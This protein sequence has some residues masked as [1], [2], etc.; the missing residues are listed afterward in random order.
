MDSIKRI[1]HKLWQT[2][3]PWWLL[4]MPAG[5]LLMLAAGALAVTGFQFTM[6]A[7]STTEFCLSC[8][9]MSDN[10]EKDYKL[11]IHYHNAKGIQA[12]CADCHIPAPFI[13]KMERKLR[14]TA[15]VYYSIT[16][17]IDTPEKFAEHKWAMASKVWAEMKANDSRECR[18]CHDIE[19]MNLAAQSKQAA[20]RHDPEKMKAANMTCID[21][22]KGVAHSLPEPPMVDE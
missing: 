11:S 22:H 20:R 18:A 1:W 9:E 12:T 4:G 7:T 5:G 15:E 13:P 6:A 21:C 17:K 3:L 19:N 14:A 10:I 16:G 2:K 8:H